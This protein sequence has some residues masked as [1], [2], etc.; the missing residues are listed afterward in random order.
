MYEKKI[1]KSSTALYQMLKV[2]DIPMDNRY[3]TLDLLCFPDLY[4][5]GKNGQH[6]DRPKHLSNSEF[7]KSRLMS[8]HSQFRLH[9]QYLFY[10]LNDTNIRQLNS[11]IYHKMNMINPKERITA[12]NFW[13][14]YQ[15]VN[16]KGILVQFFQD[17]VIQH[18]I[19]VNQDVI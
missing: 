14:Q 16:W 11:G 18:N 9:I 4:P 6:E 8:K 7:I 17:F 5:F 12:K 10:L 19:G 2:Q 1:N 13:M 3:K 15:K